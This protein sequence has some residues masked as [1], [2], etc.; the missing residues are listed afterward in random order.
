VPSDVGESIAHTWLALSI[1]DRSADTRDRVPRFR[2]GGARTVERAPLSLSAASRSSRSGADLVTPAKPAASQQFYA[3][4]RRELQWPPIR[5][6]MIARSAATRALQIITRPRPDLQTSSCLVNRQ[7]MSTVR[8]SFALSI[9]TC[10]APSKKSFQ[11]SS[12]FL[13]CKRLTSTACAAGGPPSGP[14]IS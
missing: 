4:R 6:R 12:R 10:G 8:S 14:K 3:N 11:R 13:A 2:L 1:S 7:I 5:C 9:P